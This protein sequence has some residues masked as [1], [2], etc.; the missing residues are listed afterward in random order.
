MYRYKFVKIKINRW[1]GQPEVDYRQIIEEN[2]SEGWGLVQIFA[3]PISGFGAADHFELILE[4][5]IEN[6][7]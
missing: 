1:K 7:N 6:P 2:A 5:Y 3:P 4:K